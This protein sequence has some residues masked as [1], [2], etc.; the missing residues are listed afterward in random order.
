MQPWRFCPRCG[1]PLARPAGTERGHR[2][3]TACGRHFYDNSRPCAGALV[4]RD[5]KVLLVRRGIEPFK[6][7]WDIPGGFLEPGEHPADGAAREVREETGLIVETGELLGIW[8]D[9]YAYDDAE[10]YTL[11]CYYV[12]RPIGGE[13]RADDDAAALGWFGPDEL[14]TGIAFAHAPLVLEAWRERRA[15]RPG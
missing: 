1:E 12:A 9:D 13:V 6:G 10:S 3:C 14:P 4:E 7:S 11:N 8:I 2:R 5:G 15:A